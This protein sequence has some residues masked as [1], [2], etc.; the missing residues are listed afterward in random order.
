[1]Y[2]DDD[3]FDIIT[4]LNFQQRVIIESSKNN[5]LKIDTGE[6]KGWMTPT[7]LLCADK[8]LRG[9]PEG[10]GQKFIVMTDK[11]FPGPKTI[12]CHG[13]CQ[14]L[15]RFTNYFIF[16]KQDNRFLLSPYYSLPSINPQIGWVDVD[17]G[18]RWNTALGIRPIESVC[19]YRTQDD[20]VKKKNGIPVLGGNQWFKW[21]QRIPIIGTT[22]DGQFYEVIVPLVIIVP[23]PDAKISNIPESDCQN[24]FFKGY[25]R[26]DSK[27]EL[28]VWCTAESLTKY[29][30]IL[31]GITDASKSSFGD[32]LRTEMLKGIIYS[33]EKILGKPV[34]SE[35][36][37]S[38][39]TYLSRSLTVRMD[40]PLFKYSIDELFDRNTVKDCVIEDLNGWVNNICK[41]LQ[42]V[43]SDNHSKPDFITL[44]QKRCRCIGAKGIPYI[45]PTSI[46]P[47]PF[48][49]D[50]SENKL[51]SY[52][53]TLYKTTF[54]WIPSQFLP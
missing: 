24:P 4:H 53:H 39:Q 11:A 31:K 1:V 37:E 30:L 44:S 22:K 54:Y 51:M 3:S 5:R 33:L 8:P 42:I 34:Y 15:S 7:D 40:S 20:A 13:R 49:N 46:K 52:S 23:F 25:I 14:E 19:V 21:D 9:Q 35:T 50:E 36:G 16:D 18:Y 26:K 43:Y 29:L 6:I 28:D 2:N 12:D 47:V 32:A 17:K 45:V 41:I 38:L 48:S 27:I 10:F